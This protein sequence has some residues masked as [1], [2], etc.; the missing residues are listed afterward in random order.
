VRFGDRLVG[1]IDPWWLA[2][3]G[4]SLVSLLL[5]SGWPDSAGPAS[6]RPIVGLV[7]ALGVALLLYATRQAEAQ[8]TLDQ[9]QTI[10]HRQT[11]TTRLARQAL[12]CAD[13]ALVMQEATQLVATSLDMEYCAVL[14]SRAH[15]SALV[16]RAGFG[17]PLISLGLPVMTPIASSGTLPPRPWQRGHGIQSA[18]S[19]DVQVGPL[20][21]GVLDVYTTR[22]R[23]FSRAEVQFVE[24][25][26]DVLGGAIERDRIDAAVRSRG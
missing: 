17:W 4:V 10:A 25:V 9:L 18:I 5:V 22:Q 26:A 1:A 8:L 3:A 12:T 13:L 11:L 20:A 6:D 21:Y 2:V 23:V 7:A 24:T 14:E 19:A 15:D 16:V